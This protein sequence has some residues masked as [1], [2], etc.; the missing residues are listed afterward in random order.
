[1]EASAFPFALTAIVRL[2]GTDGF[3]FGKTGES[4]GTQVYNAVMKGMGNHKA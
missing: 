1:M 4:A 2:P 3:S